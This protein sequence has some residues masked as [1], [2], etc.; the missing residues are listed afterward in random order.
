MA[1]DRGLRKAGIVIPEVLRENKLLEA[2]Q[3]HKVKMDWPKIMGEKIGQYSYIQGFEGHTVVIAVLNPVWMNHLFMY[4]TKIIEDI[5]QYCRKKLIED[6]RFFHSGKKRPHII[7]ETENGEEDA[8]IPHLKTNNIVIPKEIADQIRDET[9]NLP[10][11]LCEKVRR[12]RFSH[13]R[14]KIAYEA[15]GYRKCPNCGRWIDKKERICFFCR[16][17]ERETVKK[18]VYDILM[19]E[20]WITVQ[21][22]QKRCACSEEIYN[23]VRRDCIY[24]LIEKVFNNADTDE[25]D[26]FLTLFITRCYPADVTETFIKNLTDKYRRKKDVPSYRE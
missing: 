11:N 16:M 6:V 3:L 19:L 21:D 17:K 22:L 8:F 23:E 2:Y 10:D 12:L 25:D 20:P 14:L 7:Y 24:R 4:K 18:E 9:K 1:D 15:A 5:N 13:E 26:L